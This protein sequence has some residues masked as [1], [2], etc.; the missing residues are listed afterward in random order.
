MTILSRCLVAILVIVSMLAIP[1]SLVAAPTLE[2]LVLYAEQGDTPVLEDIELESTS[3]FI[4]G[5]L[6]RTSLAEPS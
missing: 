1:C 4:T 5:N 2:E 6:S 3:P